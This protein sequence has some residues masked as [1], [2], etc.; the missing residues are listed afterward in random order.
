MCYHY[1]KQD[2][3]SSAG[4]LYFTYALT[5]TDPEAQAQTLLLNEYVTIPYITLS[6][7]TYISP[8]ASHQMKEIARL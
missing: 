8:L 6:V 1:I 5:Q 2:L 7:F 4:T 3:V